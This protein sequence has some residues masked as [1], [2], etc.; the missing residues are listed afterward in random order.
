MKKN[1]IKVLAFLLVMG[2]LV[3]LYQK[4]IFRNFFQH[5]SQRDAFAVKLKKNNE[6]LAA[7]WLQAGEKALQ[8]PVNIPSVYFEKGIFHEAHQAISLSFNTTP[9][10]KIRIEVKNSGNRKIFT[11]LFK[12]DSTGLQI[13]AE[14]DTANMVLETESYFGEKYTVRLQ[15]QP[16]F[17]GFYEFTLS[18]APLLYWPV[19]SGAA[20][21]IGSYWGA[22][23]DGGSRSHEGV[24]I[25][26]KKGSPLVA[27]ADGYVNRVEENNLGGKV[28]FLK[29][30]QIP[31]WLYYAHLDS[32]LTEPGTKVK[33]GD[34]IGT[35]GNTGNARNTPAHLHFG[36]YTRN[37]AINPLGYIQ[38]ETWPSKITGNTL[39]IKLKKLAIKNVNLYPVADLKVPHQILKKGD[40][41][42]VNAATGNFYRISSMSGRSGYVL[43]KNI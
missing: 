34:I 39:P 43:Q 31:V 27:A 12:Q 4:G 17:T 1:D 42:Y 33:K 14:A 38:K 5:Q 15:P 2:T 28:I 24:D 22:D 21:N 26:A 35:I 11:D 8:N 20:S 23:R 29:P 13:L 7:Q 25:F 19:H 32:Q 36:I 10:R 40:T 9:G 30:D 18:T 3:V 41:I 37:G 6:P 16:G